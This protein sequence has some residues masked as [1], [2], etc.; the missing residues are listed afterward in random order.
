MPNIGEDEQNPDEIPETEP[1]RSDYKKR[2]A[3]VKQCSP[4]VR[5]VLSDVTTVLEQKVV[6]VINT[7]AT[8]LKD[9]ECLKEIQ[10]QAQ[11]FNSAALECL[12][13]SQ[14]KSITD[15]V[16][17]QERIPDPHPLAIDLID[18][19]SFGGM[20]KSEAKKIMDNSLLLAKERNYLSLSDLLKIAEDDFQLAMRGDVLTEEHLEKELAILEKL[21][22][23]V[24]RHED[25]SANKGH[26][27]NYRH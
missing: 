13:N 21:D 1:A 12:S 3:E 6:E 27:R 10:N 7:V 15:F 14:V 11:V 2:M 20:S 5:G 23:R 16:A 25:T 18:A 8:D 22:A 19:A 17:S 4:R 24:L 26:E 9:I